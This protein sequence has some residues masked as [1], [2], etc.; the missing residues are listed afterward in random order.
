M[1]PKNKRKQKIHI[2]TSILD[3]TYLAPVTLATKYEDWRDPYP[4]R[5][6][7]SVTVAEEEPPEIDYWKFS[8]ATLIAMIKD[9][10]ND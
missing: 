6:L 7:C 3:D 4:T 8:K 9:L 1:K 5:S 2:A 10:Q